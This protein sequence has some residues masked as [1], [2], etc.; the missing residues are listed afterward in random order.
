MAAHKGQINYGVRFDV[1]KQSLQQVKT[2]LQAIQKMTLQEFSIKN[3]DMGLKEAQNKLIDIKREATAL[4]G[5]LDRAFNANLG[6]LNL[7]KFD[8]ELKK[9]NIDLQSVY[10]NFKLAGATGT[11][12]FQKLSSAVLT[13]NLQLRQTHNIL[14]NIAQTMFNTVKWGIA[15]SAF[16]NMTSSIQRA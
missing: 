13:S 3:A 8:N 6:S 2:E 10:K 7:T 14:D 5:V 16:N 15:S 9:S 11:Q 4:Q 1:D 12:E